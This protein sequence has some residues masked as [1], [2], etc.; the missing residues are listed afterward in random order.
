[1]LYPKKTGTAGF[2]TSASTTTF[3]VAGVSNVVSTTN[4]GAIAV[5]ANLMQP[6]LITGSNVTVFGPF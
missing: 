3:L 5:A 6:V 4:A 1:M 2:L